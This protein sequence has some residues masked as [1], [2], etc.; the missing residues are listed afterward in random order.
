LI[1]PRDQHA[2]LR[3]FALSSPYYRDNEPDT[4]SVPGSS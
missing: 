4:A 1:E 2:V 3:L